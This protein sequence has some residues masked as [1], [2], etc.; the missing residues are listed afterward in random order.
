MSL[1]PGVAPGPS[2]EP[3]STLGSPTCERN[4]HTLQKSNNNIATYPFKQ[5]H[6][7]TTSTNYVSTPL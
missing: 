3:L 1:V 2:L 7:A 5:Q 4:Q 6:V